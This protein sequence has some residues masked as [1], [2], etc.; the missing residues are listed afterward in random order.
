MTQLMPL[1]QPVGREFIGLS[2]N[3]VLKDREVAILRWLA[4][5]Q[6]SSIWPTLF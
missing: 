1:T 4:R 2:K 6:G 5:H 3:R